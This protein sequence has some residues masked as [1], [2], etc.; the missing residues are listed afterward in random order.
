[1]HLS[2][3]QRPLE[4]VKPLTNTIAQ[5]KSI[6]KSEG[7]RTD[8]QR[9]S[10]AGRLRITISAWFLVNAY[11]LEANVSPGLILNQPRRIGPEWP[12]WM[13]EVEEE[14]GNRQVVG[15][16]SFKWITIYLSHCLLSTLGK[17]SSSWSGGR[18]GTLS[19]GKYISSG[20]YI[21]LELSFLRV[22]D[23]VKHLHLRGPE[24]TLFWTRVMDNR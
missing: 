7:S 23:D 16:H 20:E 12:P 10:T 24:A 11:L 22:L 19:S 6:G 5:G 21:S 8:L 17:C 15:D 3:A 1:M 14:L 2:G 4:Y 13:V 18:E 9:Q